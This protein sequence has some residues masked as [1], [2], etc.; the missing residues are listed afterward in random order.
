MSGY[1]SG[2]LMLLLL[3]I[4]GSRIKKEEAIRIA[5]DF[6]KING[7]TT[8]PA[9]T[10]KLSYE[11]MDNIGYE[12]LGQLL[13][14]RHNTLQAKAYD[15][16]KTYYHWYVTFLYTPKLIDSTRAVSGRVIIMNRDGKKIYMAH[17]DVLISPTVK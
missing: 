7:Y 3:S 16:S 13:K 9:D 14:S 11:F 4:S 17:Q 12:N 6:V 2:L 15:I 1:Y 8:N 10:T 5:E